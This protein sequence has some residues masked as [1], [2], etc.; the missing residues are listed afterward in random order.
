MTQNWAVFVDRGVT[1][2]GAYYRGVLLAQQLVPCIRQ[3]SF[4]FFIF[5]Q[6]SAPT[7]TARETV[8]VKHLHSSL[9]ICGRRTALTSIQLTTKSGE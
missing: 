6:D 4:D 3:I 7:H 1:I 5:Q 8:N 2:N 9:Q